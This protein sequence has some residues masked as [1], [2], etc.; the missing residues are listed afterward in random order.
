MLEE[1]RHLRKLICEI[2]ERLYRHRY[3]VAS[4]GNISVRSD[5]RHILIT[6]AGKCKGELT[7]S[8]LIKMNIETGSTAK[9]KLFPSSEY[10]LHLFSYRKNKNIK[11]IIHAHPPFS[12]TCAV[13]GL[14][15]DEFILPEVAVYIGKVP[16]I[17]YENPGSVELADSVSEKLKNFK[18]VLMANHGIV[19]A[20]DNLRQTYFNLERLEF[21]FK[22]LYLSKLLGRVNTIEPGK[23]E[24]MLKEMEASQK[25]I[26]G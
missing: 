10:R 6:P 24:K 26:K 8:D 14:S 22:V 20:G 4:D 1:E 15:M 2:G 19:V 16:L 25:T 23:I 17:S 3:I 18:A 9:S 13:A 5:D 12:T 11:C 7:E 21:A